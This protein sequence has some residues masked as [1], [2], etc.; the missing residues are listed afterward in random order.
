M[1]AGLGPQPVALET[2]DLNLK[3]FIRILSFIY[4]IYSERTRRWPNTHRNNLGEKSNRNLLHY[5]RV[6]ELTHIVGCVFYMNKYKRLPDNQHPAEKN[7][8]L[9]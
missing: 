3:L 4:S 1:R 8:S 5:Q 9:T 6:R 7:S 2:L